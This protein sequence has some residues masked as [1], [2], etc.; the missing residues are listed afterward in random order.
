MLILADMPKPI[1]GMSNVNKAMLSRLAYGNDEIVVINTVPSYAATLFGGKLW[2]L[3]KFFHTSFCILKLFYMVA[4]SSVRVVY[5]PINGGAGQVY[6]LIYIGICRIFKKDIYIH[7][8]SFNYLNSKSRLFTLLNC[9]AGSKTKHI[10]LGDRMGNI[11]S[12]LYNIQ[13]AQITIL[14]NIAFFEDANKESDSLFEINHCLVIG[15]LANL[16]EEKGIDD[17]IE[18]CRELKA[19]NI[20]F[21]GKIAGPFANKTSEILVRAS[22]D[23]FDEIEYFGGLYGVDKDSFFKSLDA[24][25]FPSKYKNEAEPLVLYEAGQYG[26]LNIGSRRGCMEDVIDGLKGIS[27]EEG[28]LMV[29]AMADTL[30]HQYNSGNFSAQARSERMS[31]LATAQVKAKC[32]LENVFNDFIGK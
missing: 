13:L 25:V 12:D 2:A 30:Q 4:F 15:H 10:V 9:I 11:L 18:L 31:A 20:E 3:V 28:P 19:R 8:H 26:V 29:T 23:E 7:H 17:F 21:I 16:C 22:L 5:R 24:F 27:I 14:S 32:V 6:D 1:H